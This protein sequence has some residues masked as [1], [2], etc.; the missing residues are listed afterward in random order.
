VQL[1]QG[2]NRIAVGSNKDFSG[3][4]SAKANADGDLVSSKNKGLPES[5]D[6]ISVPSGVESKDIDSYRKGMWQ[7]GNMITIDYMPVGDYFLTQK[8]S[9][10]GYDLD[11]KKPFTFTIPAFGEKDYAV[12]DVNSVL[13]A[14]P[15]LSRTYAIDQSVNAFDAVEFDYTPVLT[16]ESGVKN[17]SRQGSAFL[18]TAVAKVGDQM[19]VQTTVDYPK[20]IEAQNVHNRGVVYGLALSNMG[21]SNDKVRVSMDCGKTFEDSTQIGTPADKSIADTDQLRFTPGTCAIVSYI[22]TF[23]KDEIVKYSTSLTHL[24]D[25]TPSKILPTVQNS[26]YY[27]SM[28]MR[29]TS[30]V[31]GDIKDIKGVQFG[32][33]NSSDEAVKLSNIPVSGDLFTENPLGENETSLLSNSA[34]EINIQYFASGKYYLK[35]LN[36][37]GFGHLSDDTR[38]PFEI[39]E[40][41]KDTAISTDLHTKMPDIEVK[42]NPVDLEGIPGAWKVLTPGSEPVSPQTSDS[43]SNADASPTIKHATEP[44]A[45]WIDQKVLGLPML[46]FDGIILTLIIIL[47]L[48]TLLIRSNRKKRKTEEVEHE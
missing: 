40:Y 38:Y 46:V 43:S 5:K 20:D 11:T 27:S 36:A 31:D 6:Q 42:L 24:Y 44:Q 30:N 15:K 18:G 8:K 37:D 35:I 25:K 9:P 10:I 45:S 26:T 41:N 39:P 34:G 22:S 21:T 7:Q 12:D 47:L 14:N 29:I 16:I 28:T 48:S 33:F 23:S 4:W 32:V 1:N 2:G 17:L 13:D 3:I 19:E